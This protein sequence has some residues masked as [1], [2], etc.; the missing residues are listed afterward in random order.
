MNEYQ[1]TNGL[2]KH[3]HWL[4]DCDYEEVAEFVIAHGKREINTK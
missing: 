1:I 2:R 3:W 4:K